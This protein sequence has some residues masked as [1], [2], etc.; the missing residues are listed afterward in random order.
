MGRQIRNILRTAAPADRLG[1]P[2]VLLGAVLADLAAVVVFVS[3]GRNS[4]DEALSVA[5]VL[6]TGWPF[7][8]GVIGGYLGLARSGRP[9]LSRPGGVVIAVTTVVIGLVLR[10]TVAGEGTPFSFVVVTVLVLSALMLGW[11]A[12]TLWALRRGQARP[13]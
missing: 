12:G 4:H 8:A 10:H 2:G 7:A 13:V 11:R 3:I 5:G 6:G 1:T 9:V